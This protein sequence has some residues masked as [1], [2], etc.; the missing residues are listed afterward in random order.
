VRYWYF[1]IVI[2]ATYDSGSQLHQSVKLFFAVSVILQA[3]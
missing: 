1:R 3:L 2:G